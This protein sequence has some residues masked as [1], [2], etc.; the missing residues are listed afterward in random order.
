MLRSCSC[1]CAP[2]C[3]TTRL[4]L[5]PPILGKVALCVVH[6][7]V[8]LLRLPLRRLPVR[9]LRRRAT[10]PCRS[11]GPISIRKVARCG[12]RSLAMYQWWSGRNLLPRTAMRSAAA[13]SR[14]TR[15]G[16]STCSIMPA[17][18]RCRCTSSP[19][20]CAAL[21]RC[22][23]RPASRPSSSRRRGF[24]ATS[25]R[26]RPSRCCTTRG[27]SRF[28]CASPSRGSARLRSPISTNRRSR[29][30]RSSPR[31]R[32]TASRSRRRSAPSRSTICLP[33][34]P[35][36]CSTTPTFCS[37]PFQSTLAREA[38]FHGDLTSQEAAEML[39]GQPN[40]TFLFR[41][42]SYPGHLAVSY[43]ENG[44]TQH[45][46]VEM[47][48]GGY[49]FKSKTDTAALRHAAAARRRLQDAPLDASAQHALAGDRGRLP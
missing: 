1:V 24:T 39:A 46:K 47:A 45:G 40:G 16:S 32:R 9:R 42:S 30:T 15:A 14:S 36:S 31:P 27:H 37:I 11:I 28:W 20:F 29:S 18:T 5:L 41:F 25:R 26:T 13:T 7:S 3:A 2:S 8:R 17:P 35:R 23:T 43:N 44:A 12:S 34:L 19:S 38:W 33:R 48:Q 21:V 49:L 4:R 6:R 22:K 10:P